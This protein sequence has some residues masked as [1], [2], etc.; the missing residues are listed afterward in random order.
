MSS[1]SSIALSGLSVLREGL[2]AL[3]K[4]RLDIAALMAVAVAGAFALGQWPE[5]AMV[6]TLFALAERIEARSVERA[7]DAIRGLPTD[8]FFEML[9]DRVKRRIRMVGGASDCHPRKLA[10][11]SAAQGLHQPRFT[12]SRLALNQDDLTAALL[13][14]LP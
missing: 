9:D 3:V 10:S 2:T 4:G 11:E 5:A 6:M 14:H 13:A 1:V 8:C 7:R 12:D